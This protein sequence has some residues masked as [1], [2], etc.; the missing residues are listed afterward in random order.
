MTNPIL[1]KIRIAHK[2]LTRKLVKA[3]WEMRL[4][5]RKIK[6]KLIELTDEQKNEVRSYWRQ[7]GKKIDTDWV[8]YFYTMSNI[9]DKKYI[10]ESLY[11]SEI[12]PALNNFEVGGV[13]SDKNISSQLFTAKMPRTIIRKINGYYF[14][15]NYEWASF[16]E[17]IDIIKKEKQVIIK[18]SN[19][20]YGGEG[21]NFW[22]DNVGTLKG[23]LSVPNDLIVQE[24]IEQHSEL[25]KFHKESLNTIR[26][27]TLRINKEIVI[28]NT[29][30]RMGVND[31]KVDNYSAGGVISC[32]DHQGN[33]YTETVQSNGEKIKKHP[34]SKI[35]FS[36]EKIVNFNKVVQSAMTQHNRVPY[37]RLISWDYAINKWGE[38]VLIEGNYPSGQLDFHQINIGSLFGSYTDDVLSEVYK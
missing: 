35:I 3:G 31:S 10:P 12:Q 20:T 32:V 1:N 24:V 21:I 22:E 36:G 28:L 33:L 13:L 23:F 15:E 7:Y 29:I 8:S 25:A 14:T 30:L 19:D 11:Y 4:R 9:Y 27:V 18:P 34:N 38:A 2:P 37:F 17:A 26:I 5:K 16:E 6:M